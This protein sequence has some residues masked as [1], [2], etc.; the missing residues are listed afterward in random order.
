MY[1][2]EFLNQF[3]I[4]YHKC[5]NCNRQLKANQIHAKDIKDG[6]ESIYIAVF[7]CKICNIYFIKI[8]TLIKKV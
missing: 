2:M 8:K 1:P 3:R 5:G 6:K 7:Y 4:L